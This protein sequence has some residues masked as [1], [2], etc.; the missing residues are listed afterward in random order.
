MWFNMGERD[1]K[2]VLALSIRNLWK[3]NQIKKKLK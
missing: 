3:A 1:I 2:A